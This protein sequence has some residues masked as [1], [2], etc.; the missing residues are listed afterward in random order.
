METIQLDK[1]LHIISGQGLNT[2]LSLSLEYITA[3]SDTFGAAEKF[4]VASLLFSG[5][6][7][8]RLPAAGN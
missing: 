3:K 8:F 7:Q 2:A 5:Q 6:G 1:G 4:S